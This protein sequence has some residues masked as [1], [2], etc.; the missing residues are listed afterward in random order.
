M[1]KM[2]SPRG[3]YIYFYAT[4][5][6]LL[7][8]MEHTESIHRLKYVQKGHFSRKEEVVFKRAAD[9]PGFG[10]SSRG[11][12]GGDPSYLIVEG[13]RDVRFQTINLRGGGISYYM[14]STVN[15]FALLFD[16]GGAYQN[17]AI[18][19]GDIRTLTTDPAALAVLK[20]FRKLVKAKFRHIEG[21]IYVAPGA[22]ALHRQGYRLTSAV[23][24]PQEFDLV[25]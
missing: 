4:G 11:G 2:M 1:E 7:P 8:I 23:G 9:I 20:T 17:S 12:N 22:E 13:S 10:L 19:W 16:H 24:R 21:G 14:D 15:P 18:I 5:D 3:K 6:D 25:L